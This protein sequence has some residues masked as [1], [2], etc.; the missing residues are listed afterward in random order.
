MR[1]IVTPTAYRVLEKWITIA[2]ENVGK[3]IIPADEVEVVVEE[4]REKDGRKKLLAFRWYGG[5]Y[6]HLD[7]LLPLLPRTHI[8]C[9]R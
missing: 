5:K 9:A 8:F 1:I 2:E 7:W 3:G 6:S 4:L